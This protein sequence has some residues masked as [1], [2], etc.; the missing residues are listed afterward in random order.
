VNGLG[1]AGYLLCTA[2]SDLP[3]LRQHGPWELLRS[4]AAEP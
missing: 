2:E 1:F 4:V 3:W